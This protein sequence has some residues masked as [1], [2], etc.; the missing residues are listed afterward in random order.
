MCSEKRSVQRVVASMAWLMLILASSGCDAINSVNQEKTEQV[1]P[2]P[3]APAPVTAPPLTP[4]TPAPVVKTP[5]QIIDEFLAL[6]NTEK[7]DE[8][9][10]QLAGLPEGLDTITTLD[11]S[12]SGVS[13]EGM[14]SLV[15]FPKLTEL[16]LSETRVSNA[17]L[18][19]V[20]KVQTLHKLTLHSLRAVGDLGVQ[21]LAPLSHLEELTVSACPVSD[22][23]LS[24]LASFEGLQ[25]LNLSGCP[26]F[27]GRGI[28]PLL[29]QKAFR[30]LRE[31]N[32]SGSNFGNY[33]LDQLNKLPQLEVLRASRCGF[34]G[35]AIQGLTGCDRLKVLDL[36]G[37]SFFDDNMKVVSRLKNL[38]EL[39]LAQ[40]TGLT[41][42][43]MKSLKIMKHL[44]LLD[45]EG[46][47]ITEPV[48]KLHKEKF[49]K[50]TEILAL[51]QK[52]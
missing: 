15:A 32:V 13:D 7:R 8:H 23:S 22:A 38:E 11:L 40:I 28:N 25:V 52:F 16:N 48:V 31:L 17:G 43:C 19:S 21:N 12:R 51:G 29:G 33:G 45:L 34:A 4:E 44:K 37:N 20:A 2:A 14:K 46:T 30:Q 42:E 27:Y 1:V 39:R 9:L 41:D 10:Q 35:A 49:L 50:D 26:D 24:T 6:P 18:A 36:S 47:R 5:Q 3:L